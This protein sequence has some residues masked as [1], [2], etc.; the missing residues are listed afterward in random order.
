[1]PRN[2]LPSKFY[3]IEPGEEI[4]TYHIIHKP[5]LLSLCIVGRLSI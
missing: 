1:M 5:D 4:F 2:C 3:I